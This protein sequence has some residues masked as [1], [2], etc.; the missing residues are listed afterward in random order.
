MAQSAEA[1]SPARGRRLA[2][3][4]AGIALLIVVV[5]AG[6]F[7][8][9]ARGGGPVPAALSFL[10]PKAADILGPSSA[11]EAVL[12]TLRLAGYDHAVVGESGG[13]VVVR[14]DVPSVKTP[15]DVEL[16]WQTA[17]A[18]GATSYP[19]AGTVVAQLFKGE[20][21][22]VEVTADA[23][24]VRDVSQRDDGAALRKAAHFRYLP[25]SGGGMQ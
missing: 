23:D 21:S 5:G 3:T 20:L 2:W 13:I 11:E 4:L 9:Y 25:S 6:L 17:L 1:P 15:A 16:S 19:R 22:L 8:L 10:S 24:T 14:V 12:R 18:A 7:V